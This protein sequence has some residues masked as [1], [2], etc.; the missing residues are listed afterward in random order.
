MFVLVGWLSGRERSTLGNDDV[1]AVGLESC[2]SRGRT[3]GIFREDFLFL[4]DVWQSEAESCTASVVGLG[5]VS[6]NNVK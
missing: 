5:L 6:F 4:T 2:E 3:E 1:L